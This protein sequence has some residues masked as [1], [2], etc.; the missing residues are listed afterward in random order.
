MPRINV[1][2]I[3]M[4]YEVHGEG[5]PLALIT[6]YNGTSEG[7]PFFIDL[8]EF[9][10]H[11]KCI[12]LDNRGIGKTSASEGPY[13]MKVMASDVVGLLDALEIPEAHIFGGSMGGMIAQEVALGHPDKVMS[14]VLV[15]TSPGGKKCWELPGQLEAYY[16]MS[17]DHNPPDDLS[18][19]EILDA[20]LRM[21]FSDE[22]TEKNRSQ[23]SFSKIEDPGLVSTLRKQYDSFVKHD[24]YDRLPD[25][26]H[27]TLILHGEM[28]G[29]IFSE[30]ARMLD[31]LIP[32]SRLV[33]FEGLK[34]NFVVEDKDRFTEIVLDFLREVES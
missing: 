22:Y 29:L 20:R 1:N 2:D 14:L 15:G 11:H 31:E 12:L 19:A 26:K 16:K 8:P 17:W 9:S 33:L 28:D 30:S 21:F 23:L 24:A 3:E 32:N 10:K 13:S 5:T 18:D 7:G 4:Y 27:K 34:H 25:V 6:G